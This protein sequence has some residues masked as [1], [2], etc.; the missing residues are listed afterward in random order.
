MQTAYARSSDSRIDVVVDSVFSFS[1]VVRT[2]TDCSASCIWFLSW[3]V[4]VWLS[5]RAD[6]KG[7]SL[8]SSISM[9]AP[10]FTYSTSSV[11]NSAFLSSMNC[12]IDFFFSSLSR[13]LSLMRSKS[14]ATWVAFFSATENCSFTTSW[15]YNRVN[16]CTMDIL[17]GL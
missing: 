7:L 9:F 15:S 12:C 17:E 16:I 13:H 11:C 8:F 2:E 10:T 3:V 1:L 14:S 6:F 4:L 5:S